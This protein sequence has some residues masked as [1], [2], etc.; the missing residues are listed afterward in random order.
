MIFRIVSLLVTVVALL[1]ISACSCSENSLK[2]TEHTNGEVQ[3]AQ[4]A[5]KAEQAEFL[6]GT[7]KLVKTDDAE[8]SDVRGVAT[9][10]FTSDGRFVFQSINFIRGTIQKG[11]GTYEVTGDTIRLVEDFSSDRPTESWEIVI[12]TLT[13]TELT[14]ITGPAKVRQRSFFRRLFEHN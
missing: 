10:E 11:S 4:R 6:V 8:T 1:G 14:T 2:T 12:E 7:W 13:K 9:A 5:Q 3:P